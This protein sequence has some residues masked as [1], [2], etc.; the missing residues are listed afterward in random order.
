M[1]KS[2][3]LFRCQNCGQEYPRWQGRCDS[4]GEWN[5]LVEEVRVKQLATKKAA[6]QEGKYTA[7][8]AKTVAFSEVDRASGSKRRVSTGIGELDRVLGES[9]L[10][11]GSVAGMVP[12]AVML[13]G[14]EP[15]IGKSTLL[16]QVVLKLIASRD[17]TGKN[18]KAGHPNDKGSQKGR[19]LYVAGEES[20]HQITLRIE[21]MLKNEHTLSNAKFGK[22]M[23]ELLNQYLVFTTSTDVDELCTLIKEEQPALLIV[24]SI[25]TLTTQ[26]LTGSSGSIGQI[27]EG[28]ERLIERVK[29]LQIPTFLVGHVTKEGSIA[30]PKVLEHMVDAVLELSG[31]RTGQL[32]I[33]RSIKNRFGATDE[34]GVF[35]IVEGGLEEVENP[36][37]LFLE[38]TEV[39]VPGAVTVC[40]ME[41]TRPLL[42]EVQAL[43]VDSQLAMPRRVGRGIELS[44]IQVLAAVL[45]K[46]ARLPLGTTDIFLS[47]AG[48]F[49]VR[50]PAVDLGLAVAVASSLKNKAI[51]TKTVFIGEVGLLGEIRSVQ[52][53]ERRIKE[54]KRLGFEHIIS[55][56]DFKSVREVLKEFQLA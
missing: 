50:E 16:T 2:Q 35:Q 22:N 38:Q 34:V 37:Q 52:Y 4:C 45:Q 29:P 25:Q 36:S 17:S 51:P 32:R 15:G 31:E 24:D 26:D 39:A 49:S 40:V 42:L 28:T 13:L 21:R 46:H 14:G 53:L 9:F 10:E 56:K 23:G 33:L 8:A 1:A 5:T 30:G 18:P 43:V 6:A 12:G 27:R 7:N 48:G 47:V 11:K 20:P 44:R 3:S 55:R 54:A 41:G 19:I